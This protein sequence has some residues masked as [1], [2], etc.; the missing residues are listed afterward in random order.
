MPG[1]P[2]GREDEMVETWRTWDVVKDVP[3]EHKTSYFSLPLGKTEGNLPPY[4]QDL[5][6]EDEKEWILYNLM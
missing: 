3:G 4:L 2:K 5:G 1:K 6:F